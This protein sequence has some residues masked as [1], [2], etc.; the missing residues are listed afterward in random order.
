[1]ADKIEGI[2]KIA[3][4]QHSPHLVL[5]RTDKLPVRSWIKPATPAEV[6]RHTGPLGI[7][8]GRSG[9]A[10]LDVDQGDHAALV[11]AHPPLAIVGTPSGGV[12]LIYR[13]PGEPLG[14]RKFSLYG[15]D[16]DV[17]A[18]KGYVVMWDRDVWKA[19]LR[20]GRPA[21]FPSLRALSLTDGIGGVA[22]GNGVGRGK[23][24]GYDAAT[25]V[26]NA[27]DTSPGWEK[28]DRNNRLNRLVFAAVKNGHH[29]R[30]AE[31]KAEAMAAGLD[32]VEVA[33]TIA[34]ATRAA[35]VAPADLS[36]RVRQA[37]EAGRYGVA[38]LLCYSQARAGVVS[39]LRATWEVGGVLADLLDYLR[40]KEQNIKRVLK[41]LHDDD[42]NKFQWRESTVHA[43]AQL[44]RERWELVETGG[45]I[46]KALFQMRERNMTPADLKK[47]AAKR[48]VKEERA[49]IA[50][51]AETL[52]LGTQVEQL[53]LAVD[54]LTEWK[55]SV[56]DSCVCGAC[57]GALTVNLGGS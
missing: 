46:R 45:S 35:R 37:A 23:F 8:P 18:D 34:S 38:L 47:Q 49:D 24:S 21:T 44:G 28:G 43:Y 4:P 27:L 33:A 42:S 54:R 52:R 39:Q 25:I 40:E 3:A 16:G 12:H 5:C 7:V 50:A 1:M 31:L 10:V 57:S 32:G 9:L 41:D 48:T 2:R 14:N 13:H 53:Q 20:S 11:K 19:A 15:C 36:G 6:A 30:I 26:S 29:W 51:T 22:S 17:R 55:R 56:I